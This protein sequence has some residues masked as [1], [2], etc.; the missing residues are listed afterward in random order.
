MCKKNY[1]KGY[2]QNKVCKFTSRGTPV[3]EEA[4]HGRCHSWVCFPRCNK[5][6]VSVSRYPRPLVFQ[7]SWILH[8]QH[9]PASHLLSI[10]AITI[11]DTCCYSFFPPFLVPHHH[12]YCLSPANKDPCNTPLLQLQITVT[13]QRRIPVDIIF[14]LIECTGVYL[15]S[16]W[17]RIRRKGITLGS[18]WYKSCSLQT[19]LFKAN[20][21]LLL[22][23][24]SNETQGM[25][26]S[27]N[28]LM[29]EE[30]YSYSIFLGLL[31][32]KK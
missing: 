10:L 2:D 18:Q 15:D 5:S 9:L 21:A 4:S 27:K 17:R 14:F 3:L 29:E 31:L 24:M 1:P 8:L 28:C 32:D 11:S 13:R 26:S 30:I 7:M 6:C 20:A 25:V 19:Q 12:D 16:I 23:F 22:R